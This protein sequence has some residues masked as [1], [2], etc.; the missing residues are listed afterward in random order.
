MKTAALH[1]QLIGVLR[2]ISV[3][4]L[5][6]WNFFAIAQPVVEGAASRAK[7]EDKPALF[8]H[9]PKSS[10]LKLGLSE[11]EFPSEGQTEK[12]RQEY[13]NVGLDLNLRTNG[14]GL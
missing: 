3:I 4:S 11:Q 5:M 6:T 10:K 2:T 8:L 13:T 14:S 7:V 9:K 12:Q 1:G